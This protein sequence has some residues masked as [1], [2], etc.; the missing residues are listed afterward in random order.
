MESAGTAHRCRS[1]SWQAASQGYA[2]L[3]GAG[4]GLLLSSVLSQ[5]DLESW[6]WRIPFILGLLIGPVGWYIRRCLPET[7]SVSEVAATKTGSWRERIDLRTTLLAIGL[8][9]SGTIGM[10]LFVFYMPAYLVTS[11]HYPPRSAMAIGCVTSACLALIT[12]IA[13]RFA[14]RHVLR[15]KLLVWTVSL[16]VVMAWPAF[17]LLNQSPDLYIAMLVVT[18]LILPACVGAGAFFALI[19]EAFA[20]PNRVLGTAVS[21]SFGV[22][23][24]GGFS[25]L[26]ATWL[27][28]A[29]NDPLAPALYLLAGGVLS[30][31]CLKLFPENP[32]RE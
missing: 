31:T 16:P 17:W 12:P 22:T 28:T 3:L 13:A 30:L 9:A 10:Y 15:K 6:G 23:L 8:M 4:I 27:T 26:I 32:G 1:I 19:M 11:M 24:F 29:L 2:A 25:P 21:Y 14:D 7:H 18:L 5:P 20:K